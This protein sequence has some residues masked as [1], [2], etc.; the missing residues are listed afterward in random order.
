MNGGTI[1]TPPIDIRP[2]HWQIIRDIL[3]THVPGY[4]V[5]AF[6]SRVK[7]TARPYSD[8]DLAL[9]SDEPLALD[10]RAALMEA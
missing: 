5:W 10:I 7:G 2:E 1:S 4:V 9:I 6:G 8:L 3:Q